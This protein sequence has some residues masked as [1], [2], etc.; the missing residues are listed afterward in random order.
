[1]YVYPTAGPTPGDLGFSDLFAGKFPSLPATDS[2][3]PF[4]AW[5]MDICNTL[6]VYTNVLQTYYLLFPA[7]SM[8]FALNDEAS[9]RQNAAAILD[10]TDLLANPSLWMT[11]RYM[12]RTR[13]LSFTRRQL[14][15]AFCRAELQSGT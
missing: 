6:D 1:M 10:R 3:T 14:L 9:V 8:V 4:N 2:N 15:R 12:P 7:M 13:D 11:T 5:N